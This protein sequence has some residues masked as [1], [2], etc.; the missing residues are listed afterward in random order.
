M[1]LGLFEVE[2]LFVSYDFPN[3]SLFQKAG[4]CRDLP[5]ESLFDSSFSINERKK[6]ILEE[7]EDTQ[8]LFAEADV[9]IDLN[10]HKSHKSRTNIRDHVQMYEHGAYES[11]ELFMRNARQYALLTLFEE[12]SLVAKMKA[13][14]MCARETL[15]CA[16]LRLGVKI[17]HDFKGRG[18]SLAD[19][20]AEGSAGLI[21]G[22]DKYEAGRGAKV[23]SYVAWWIK[24]AMHRAI[25]NTSRIIRIPVQSA[26]KFQKI[27]RAEEEAGEKY[28]TNDDIAAHTGMSI[29]TVENLRGKIHP[30]TSIDEPME[31]G[32]PNQALMVQ[33]SSMEDSILRTELSNDLYEAL[34]TLSPREQFVLGSRFGLEHTEKLTLTQ[35]SEI[36]GRTR[37]RIRQIERGAMAKLRVI[38]AQKGYAG[39]ILMKSNN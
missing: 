12:R 20:V 7:L 31:D 3:G 35:I 24:Q 19:L 10:G 34:H 26:N 8:D 33:S 1:R 18:L 9:V 15:I 6:S 32:R 23:S 21:R 4:A 36:V 25:A 38:L 28:L 29:K 27:R 22:I 5:K 37:E 17:A 13:G 11:L 16:N 2:D 14:D 30:P 39:D